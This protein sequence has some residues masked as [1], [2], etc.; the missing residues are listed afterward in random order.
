MTQKQTHTVKLGDTQLAFL[1]TGLKTLRMHYRYML[2]AG[3]FIYPESEADER[4]GN[5]KINQATY[6]LRKFKKIQQAAA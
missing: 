6:L 1:I 2:P 3:K 5:K 4:E